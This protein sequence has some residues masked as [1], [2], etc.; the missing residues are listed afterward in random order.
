MIVS[1][2][3]WLK[4]GDTV[5]KAPGTAISP[6]EDM[7]FTAAWGFWDGVINSWEKLQLVIAMASDGEVIELSEDCLA[8]PTDAGLQVD[9]GRNLT[10]DLKGHSIS[11]CL[12]EPIVNG[13]VICN[14]GTLTIGGGTITGNATSLWGGG[15][16]LRDSND[17]VLNLNG[18]A[19]TANT[20]VKN[21]GGVHVSGKSK[22]RACGAP[23]VSGNL[24]GTTANNI[25]LASGSIIQIT[26]EL[27]DGAALG[28][29]RS[30]GMGVVTSG[31]FGENSAG[32]FISDSD[33]Y[34]VGL[35]ENSEAV[36][37]S[38]ATVS[39]QA[40]DDTVA[41]EMEALTV[42]CKSA[43]I[44]P[45]ASAFLA[46]AGI[47]FRGWSVKIG[48]AGPVARMP[49]E[50]ITITADTIV[51][52]VWAPVPTV[53]AGGVSGSINDGMELSFTFVIPDEVLADEGACVTLTNER[54]YRTVTLPVKDAD[55]VDGRG[56][57][58][59][60]PL[61]TGEVD[62]TIT[63]KIFDDRG[64]PLTILGSGGNDYTGSG[65]QFTL[66]RYLIWLQESS[67]DAVLRM[68]D[69]LQEIGA[70]AFLQDSSLV[71]VILS[72]SLT[73]IGARAFAGSSVRH[74]LLPPGVES[75]ADD[76]F[77]G[78]PLEY[79]IAL[80]DYGRGWCED[81]NIPLY[82]LGSDEAKL[83]TDF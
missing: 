80:G 68:P 59:S 45:D 1:K 46:P 75:I 64:Y 28:V 3:G 70:E 36:L 29:S 8:G 13:Y 53:T 52:G 67:S 77:E 57:Q 60:I 48:N 40:G 78:C 17:A 50:T 9:P 38:P 83:Y 37:G 33:A 7:V 43:L 58:F 11:R 10:I 35:N 42:A 21:G 18:G 12:T 30:G 61:A 20:S 49:E 56:Y 32:Y 69:A 79:A 65:V 5:P 63:G 51:T 26:D 44:L 2:S 19:I 16:Y 31:L 81:H 41:G 47:R 71:D 15:V 39:F 27:T 74:V 82:A 25:N 54:T 14:E 66:M 72:R 24:K 76:A 73:S 6:T 34:L 23:V 62:D 22:M 55:L 4:D